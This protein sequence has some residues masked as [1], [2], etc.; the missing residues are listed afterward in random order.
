M[1]KE[2]MN[3]YILK[4]VKRVFGIPD[5]KYYAMSDGISTIFLIALRANFQSYPVKDLI[6]TN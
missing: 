3:G 4:A 5:F 6:L 1:Q 2:N